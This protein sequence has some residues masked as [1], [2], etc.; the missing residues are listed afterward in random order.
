MATALVNAIAEALAACPTA[1]ED[2]DIDASLWLT[3]ANAAADA[4]IAVVAALPSD[5]TAAD[6]LAVLRGE[7]A[8]SEPL[9]VKDGAA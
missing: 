3:E 7:D 1:V 9:P 4:V 6:V 2:W 5:Y 8:P